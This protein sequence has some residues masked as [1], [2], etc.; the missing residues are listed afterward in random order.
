MKPIDDIKW[1][2]RFLELAEH[3]STWSKDPSTK[4]GATLITMDCKVASLGYNG[5]PATIDDDMIHDREFKIQHVIH[6]ELNCI[7]NR[8]LYEDSI[9]FVSKPMC[10]DCAK[11]VLSHPFIKGV[12]WKT[13]DAFS[14]RWQTDKTLS[15][16]RIHFNSEGFVSDDKTAFII[17][18]KDYASS[19]SPIT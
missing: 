13:D 1:R 5:L 12:V 8:N 10:Q 11:L 2:N 4:V 18:K 16:L 7:A 19:Q 6:A 15:M 9:L 17:K 14:E 3:V